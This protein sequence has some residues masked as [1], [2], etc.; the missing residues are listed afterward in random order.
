MCERTPSRRSRGGGWFLL[1]TWVVMMPALATSGPTEPA[2]Q[3]YC[4]TGYLLSNKAVKGDPAFQSRY[5]GE[6]YYFTDEE[7]KKKFEADPD[8][9]LPQYGGWC[10]MALGGPYGN[11]IP[12]DPEVFMVHEGKLY[13]FSSERAKNAYHEKPAGVLER[14][15]S[16]FG[17]PQLGGLCPVSYLTEEKAVPGDP[18]YVVVVRRQ[19]YHLASAEAKAAFTRDPDRFLPQYN[20]S[21]ATSLASRRQYAADPRLF[22]VVDGKTYLFRDDDAKKQFEANPSQTIE[23]ADVNSAK[24]QTPRQR[25]E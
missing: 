10:T 14:A 21:C 22:H 12:G 17:V 24:V 4:L 20:G 9:F 25:R 5:A 15:A 11:R 1:L 7:A 3:G 23:K 2:L 16:L 8:R 6:M 19:V 18:K 13:L